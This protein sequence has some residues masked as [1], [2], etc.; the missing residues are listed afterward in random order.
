MN[1]LF[2]LLV[3]CITGNVTE[4]RPSVYKSKGNCYIAKANEEVY[5]NK[6]EKITAVCIEKTVHK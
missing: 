1:S 3:I 4:I 5:S 6:C 2:V